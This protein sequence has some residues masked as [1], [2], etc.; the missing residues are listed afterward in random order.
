[1]WTI[2]VFKTPTGELKSRIK[3]IYAYRHHLKHSKESAPIGKMSHSRG[4]TQDLHPVTNG[5]PQHFA[6]P[7]HQ[8]GFLLRAWRLCSPIGPT[9]HRR[10]HHDETAGTDT[11]E[12][13]FWI[14]FTDLIKQ[15]YLGKMCDGHAASLTNL[16]HRFSS[17]AVAVRF[18]GLPVILYAS[19][20]TC[21]TH[22][23]RGL[24]TRRT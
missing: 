11:V 20:I 1:M 9:K 17:C 6:S 4:Q 8:V 18:W 2:Q 13:D 23:L 16:F 15:C 7:V 21:G 14:R 10:V 12:L 19:P 3:N 5:V 24:P 22:S